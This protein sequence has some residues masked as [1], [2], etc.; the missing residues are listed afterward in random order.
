MGIES[1]PTVFLVY[2]GNVVDSFTGLPN[3]KRLNEFFSSIEL[4]K[5]IGEDDE[6]MRS[7]LRGADEWMNKKQWEQAENMFHEAMS[8]EKW[9]NKYGAIIKLGLGNEYILNIAI[10]AYNKNNYDLTEKL[11]KELNE[12]W[13]KDLKADEDIRKRVS[14]LEI[15][16]MS[17]KN[18]DLILSKFEDNFSR[19]P[20]K[21]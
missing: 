4:L 11:I 8:Y 1:V 6:I 2:K 15:K 13:E 16:V 5:R 3:E 12:K 19:K 17:R 10:C 20:G 18:P 21:S 14:N 7:L 9:R